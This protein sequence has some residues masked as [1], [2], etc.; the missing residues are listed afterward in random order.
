MN[1]PPAEERAFVGILWLLPTL[2]ERRHQ[3]IDIS[4]SLQGRANSISQS[5][6]SVIEDHYVLVLILV[7]GEDKVFENGF[8]GSKEFWASV[9]L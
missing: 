8:E 7:K 9:L 5:A 4:G 6:H 1:V 2:Q 3:N